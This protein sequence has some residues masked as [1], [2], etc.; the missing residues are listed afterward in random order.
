M[1]DMPARC[2]AAGSFHVKSDTTYFM[3]V[4]VTVRVLPFFLIV[5]LI[6]SD[7][8]IVSIL[9]VRSYSDQR[10][11]SMQMPATHSWGDSIER[12][13]G[14]GPS[15]A[16]SEVGT[17]A[18]C[19]PVSGGRFG[20]AAVKTGSAAG[21]SAAEEPAEATTGSGEFE[22]PAAASLTEVVTTAGWSRVG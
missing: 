5:T 12:T 11:L 20:P 18:S 4:L 21:I 22:S 10:Y 15:S 9:G 17:D 14:F 16:G 8:L 7:T 3:T 6:R 13:G 19:M 1:S 2:A